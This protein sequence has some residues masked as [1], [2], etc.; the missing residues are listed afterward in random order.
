MPTPTHLRDIA[1]L[2]SEAGV[3][4]R[5]IRYYGELGLLD[6]EARGPGGRR[7]YGEDALERLLFITRL[8]HLG[9][10]LE[11]IGN[12]NHAFDR[13]QT[14]AMLTHLDDLLKTRLAEVAER[15][16]E[17]VQLDAELRDYHERIRAKM[18]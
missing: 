18:A 11:E 4:S 6:I 15:Q 14:S 16:A 7:L 1:D 3:S 13:G 12:L 10:T 2:A 17:L 5:T 8:K 9:M